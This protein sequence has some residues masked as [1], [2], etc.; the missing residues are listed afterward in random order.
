[1]PSLKGKKVLYIG[2]RFFGYEKEIKLML[3]REGASVDYYNERPSSTFL[4]KAYIRLKLQSLIY[5]KIQNYYNDILETIKDIEFDYVF[6]VKIE[7]IDEKILKS[8]KKSQ[9]NAKFI[10]YMWDSLK[11]YKQNNK[12]LDLFDRAYTFD[13]NDVKSYSN[14]TFLPLFYIAKYQNSEEY[15]IKN[16][17]CFIGSGHS[18]RYLVVKKL[19]KIASSLNLSQYTFFFLQSKII[20]IFR[21]IFDKRM[22]DAKMEEFSFTSLSQEEI[23]QTML[24]SRAIVD[25]EHPG[26]IG[27]TM[28]TIEMIGLKKKL[29]T[30]NRSI[31]E[32]D[33]YNENNIYIINRN[34]LKLDKAFFDLP[35]QELDDAIYKKYSLQN[36]IQTIF[37]EGM[38][39]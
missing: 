36:W 22:R 34:N 28:R 33:F 26:Q 16:D 25:I 18:D 29:I 14:L 39:N 12:I 4:T 21:K 13:S 38:N 37:L 32:Y 10:L 9:P 23:I 35:Y 3:E 8:L 2:Q 31:K 27:L 15:K 30:T 1:M 5:L 17:L 19:F 20:F 11:N 7:T 24:E 6:I